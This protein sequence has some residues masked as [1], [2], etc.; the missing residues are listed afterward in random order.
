MIKKNIDKGIIWEQNP[1]NASSLGVC[2]PVSKTSPAPCLGCIMP[3]QSSTT[4][5]PHTVPGA[6]SSSFHFLL[7]EANLFLFSLTP[8]KH[9]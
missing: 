5:K 8:T 1:V 4:Q 3:G 2:C 7:L 6:S 9:M